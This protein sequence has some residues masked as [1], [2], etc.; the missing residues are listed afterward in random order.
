MRS[1]ALSITPWVAAQPLGAAWIYLRST[2]PEPGKGFLKVEEAAVDLCSQHWL[3]PP[4]LTWAFLDPQQPHPPI[5]RTHLGGGR[6]R[7][8]VR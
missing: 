5:P 2:Y 3:S 8:R 1:R 6:M 4:S 7:P